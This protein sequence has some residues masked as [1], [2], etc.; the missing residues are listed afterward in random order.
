[1]FQ[2]APRTVCVLRALW[3]GD[4]LCAVPTLRALRTAW[5]DAHVA[6][7]GLRW[8]RAFVD[9]Y[10]EYVDELIEMPGVPGLAEQPADARGLDAFTEGMRK[11]RFDL[12]IQLQ[13][14]GRVS[15]PFV[16]SW[17]AARTAGF[18]HPD[19]RPPEGGEFVPYLDTGHEASRLLRILPPLG[20]PSTGERLEFPITQR[21]A[22]ALRAIPAATVLRPNAYAVLHPG[23]RGQ[24]R[25]WS[26]AAFARVADVLAGRGLDVVLTGSAEEGTLTRAVTGAA[27]RAR[28][29]DVAGLTSLGA[30]GALVD[31]ARLV[32]C[33]DTGISHIADG[34]ATPSVV[35]SQDGEPN[36]WAPTNRHLHRVV[37]VAAGAGVE[38]VIE[39][40]TDLLH[41][42]DT[43]VA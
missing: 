12:A 22:A 16:L 25:Q 40:A 21:D 36:R 17:C 42:A 13:G 32:V 20:V 35:V 11:R 43:R 14:N 5:P 18:H 2:A 38:D 26:P 23:S 31:G 9:R 28:P 19:M 15:N 41:V 8:A 30:L 7:V 10:P 27:T 3:L 34:L 24:N 4:L 37:N 1:M 33:N 29:V 6:L 39:H